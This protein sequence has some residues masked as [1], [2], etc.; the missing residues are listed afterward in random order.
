MFITGLP[1]VGKLTVATEL[2]SQMEALGETVRLVDNHY[3]NNVIFGLVHQDGKTPLPA[4][5]WDAVGL[6]RRAVHS[7][8][9]TTSPSDWSFVF[10]LA[11]GPDEAHEMEPFAQLAADRGNAFL[12]VR[13][14][15]EVDE[16][17][18]RISLPGRAERM[19]ANDPEWI[20]EVF[21]SGPLVALDHPNTLTLDVTTMPPAQSA[22]EILAALTGLQEV[23]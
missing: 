6:V 12:P 13:L 8:I 3:V 15:C 14:H 17:A 9:A 2:V 5:V 10:T 22:S 19:K 11:L 4:E 23:D 7:T 18:R 21:G 20:R 16:L 1:G